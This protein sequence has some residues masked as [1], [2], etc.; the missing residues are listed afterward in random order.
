MVKIKNLIFK[1]I[2]FNHLENVLTQN[3]SFFNV[4]SNA[5]VSALLPT[6]SP[7]PL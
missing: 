4:K 5:R 7:G 3:V 2:S 6:V 1:K